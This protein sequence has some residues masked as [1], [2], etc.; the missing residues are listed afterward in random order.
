MYDALGHFE[1][2]VRIDP[3][4]VSAEVNLAAALEQVGQRDEAI[5]RLETAL[6]TRPDPAIRQRLDRLTGA[7]LR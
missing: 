5:R 1:E 2:A 6:R 3:A 4:N 7:R